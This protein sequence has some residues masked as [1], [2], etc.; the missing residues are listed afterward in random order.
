[1][2]LRTTLIAMVVA[3]LPAAALAQ[4]TS[5]PN[6]DQRQENQQKRIDQGVQSGQL[7]RKRRGSKKARRMSTEWKAG[8]KPTAR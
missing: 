7:T 3:V 5:T 1:M 8:R 4:S 2:K 6:I